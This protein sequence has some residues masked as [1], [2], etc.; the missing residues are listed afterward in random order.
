MFSSGQ[1]ML[2]GLMLRGKLFI[3]KL[4]VFKMFFSRITLLFTTGQVLPQLT[5]D[6]LR[7]FQFRQLH[8]NNLFL[9]LMLLV[10]PLI[11]LLISVF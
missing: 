4:P 6:H 2:S 8:I 10:L 3:N 9:F 11:F 5:N 1:F 7:L